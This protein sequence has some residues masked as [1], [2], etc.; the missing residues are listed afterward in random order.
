V[1]IVSNLL[2]GFTA[3]LTPASLLAALAGVLIGTLVGVL[4]GIGP[5]GAMAMLLGL[6]P[7]IGSTHALIL[8]AGIYYGAAYGGSTTSILLG[9]PGEASAVMTT[10]EGH[11]MAKQG[12]AGP[13]L[14]IAAI[15]SFVAGSLGLVGLMLLAPPLSDLAVSFG[16]PEYLLLVL[17]GLLLLVFLTPGS[18]MRSLF[19]VF[20]GLA[21]GTVGLDTLSGEPRFTFDSVDLAQGLGLAPIIM[22]VFGLAEILRSV[23][24]SERVRVG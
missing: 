14:S 23:A 19:M 16:A 18:T 22:G 15:G 12:R 24:D 2:D 13:A 5:L 6:T 11:A 8:F 1:D 20:L 10:L 4:P 7:T 17:G 9:M 21:A 3:A